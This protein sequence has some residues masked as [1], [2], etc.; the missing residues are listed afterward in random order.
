MFRVTQRLGPSLMARYNLDVLIRDD[1]NVYRPQG[2]LVQA[3]FSDESMLKLARDVGVYTTAH[4]N[5]THM[6]NS[7]AD[8]ATD[9]LNLAGRVMVSI[10]VP[11]LLELGVRGQVCEA[12]RFQPGVSLVKERL[13][14]WYLYHVFGLA[15]DGYIE[16]DELSRPYATGSRS[17]HLAPHFW[18]PYVGAYGCYRHL[19]A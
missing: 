3:M 13:R 6:L 10:L 8:R 15:R 5:V 4:E 9:L 7:D 19:A 17:S 16:L 1:R 14:G 11:T 2:V 12:T 18:W